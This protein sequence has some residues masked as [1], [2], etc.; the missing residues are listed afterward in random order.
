MTY[1]ISIMNKIHSNYITVNLNLIS[2]F[3]SQVTYFLHIKNWNIHIM[4]SFQYFSINILSMTKKLRTVTHNVRLIY[5]K[6]HIKFE[7]NPSIRN[8]DNCN[9]F[10]M[11]MVISIHLPFILYR[12]KNISEILNISNGVDWRSKLM[13]HLEKVMTLCWWGRQ[14]DSTHSFPLR[15]VENLNN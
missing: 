2:S 8:Q 6:H 7:I 11:D 10:Q 5:M 9:K 1:S 14:S 4:A 12:K 13:L 3:S 15:R